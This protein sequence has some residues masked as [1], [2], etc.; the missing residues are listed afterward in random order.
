MVIHRWEGLQNYI[1]FPSGV[2]DLS[3]TWG[4]LIHWS[5]TKETSS[6]N[7]WLWKPMGKLPRKT[8]ELNGTENPLLKGLVHSLTQPKT[9]HKNTRL[10]ST[11]IIGECDATTNLEASA[12]ESRTCW[13]AP[14]GL[15]HW[16]KSFLQSQ[17]M[18]SILKLAGA[19]LKF[20]L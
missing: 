7:T 13:D 6:Q 1:Y 2:R 4:I 16:C 8:I 3:S 10:K 9:Q 15:R 20:S 18:L 11:R 14:W 12:G 17:A 19:I 5:Y